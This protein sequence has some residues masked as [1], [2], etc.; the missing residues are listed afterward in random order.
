M[1]GG[2]DAEHAACGKCVE[3]CRVIGLIMLM[4]MIVFEDVK[5]RA[6]DEAMG[7]TD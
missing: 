6:V 2:C 3:L 7:N 5:R 1:L 4:T